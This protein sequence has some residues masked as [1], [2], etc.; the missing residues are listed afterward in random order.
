MSRIHR[1]S[2]SVSG[3][4]PETFSRGERCIPEGTRSVNVIVGTV[5]VV[6]RARDEGRKKGEVSRIT[7]H[8]MIEKRGVNKHKIER[9][10]RVSC[11]VY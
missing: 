8:C 10:F 11:P 3:R 2:E 6:V 1:C 4:T 5:G 7:V 9:G